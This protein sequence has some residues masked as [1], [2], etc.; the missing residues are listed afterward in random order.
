MSVLS[1]VMITAKNQSHFRLDF[2]KITKT[3]VIWGSWGESLPLSRWS[4]NSIRSFYMHNYMPSP[5][6]IPLSLISIFHRALRFLK[7]QWTT[8]QMQKGQVILTLKQNK[9]FSI[10]W[11]IFTSVCFPSY[12]SLLIIQIIILWNCSFPPI[13]ETISLWPYGIYN[14]KTQKLYFLTEHKQ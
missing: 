12:L 10:E 13:P 5:Y 11:K 1:L 14:L 4:Y 6:L 7:A 3:W 2:F 8:C 9:S